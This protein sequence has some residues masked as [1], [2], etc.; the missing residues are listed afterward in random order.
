[1]PTFLLPRE[2]VASIDQYMASGGGAGIQ[3]AHAIGRVATIE[4]VSQSGLRGRGGGGFP[5]GQKWA[6][7]AQ[8]LGS[9][10]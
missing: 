9:R 5:T 3:R 2:G 4:E 8:Q 6:G 7:I 1:M 10:R